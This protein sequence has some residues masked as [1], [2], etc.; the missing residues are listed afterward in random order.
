M[1]GNQERN[2]NICLINWLET[3]L[4]IV[5]NKNNCIKQSDLQKYVITNY[6]YYRYYEN[7]GFVKQT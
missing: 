2:K 7:I 6:F 4:D 1:Y 3:K 5:E